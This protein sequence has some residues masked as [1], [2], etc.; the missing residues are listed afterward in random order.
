MPTTASSQSPA[1]WTTGNT[2]SLLALQSAG[3]LYEQMLKSRAATE[4][5]RTSSKN[6]NESNTPKPGN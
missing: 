1:V 4:T 2:S 5:G 3:V 6:R